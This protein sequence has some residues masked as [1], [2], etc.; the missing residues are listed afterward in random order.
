MSCTLMSPWG[1]SPP[2]LWS[3]FPVLGL[4]EVANRYQICP[5]HHVINLLTP[6]AIISYG[7]W[8]NLTKIKQRDRHS[9]DSL[10]TTHFLGYPSSLHIDILLTNLSFLFTSHWPHTCAPRVPVSHGLL[11]ASGCALP[12]GSPSPKG[13]QTLLQLEPGSILRPLLSHP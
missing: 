4:L 7:P 8:G 12:S 10:D 5:F 3:H 9:C 2:S 1:P 11:S 13:V 6:H